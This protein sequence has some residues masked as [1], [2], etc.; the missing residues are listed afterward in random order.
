MPHPK[1]VKGQRRRNFN[2]PGSNYPVLKKEQLMKN[3][4]GKIV[5]A[6][7]HALGKEL[8]ENLET[9]GPKGW[10]QACSEA[11]EK[12]GYWPVP[13][14]KGTEFYKLTKNIYKKMQ[15]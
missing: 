11:S 5:S 2:S 15:D 9:Y 8:W 4:K 13:I 1:T 10:N 12:L 14:R 3:E 6:K 7:K